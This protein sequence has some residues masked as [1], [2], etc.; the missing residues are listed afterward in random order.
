[1]RRLLAAVFLVAFVMSIGCGKDNKTIPP[2]EIPPQPKGPPSLDGKPGGGKSP[3]E[4]P[5]PVKP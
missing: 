4:A 3:T 5:E 1:M 2:G